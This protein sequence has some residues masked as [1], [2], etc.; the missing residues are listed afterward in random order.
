MTAAGN[1]AMAR[2]ESLASQHE[3][4]MVKFIGRDLRQLL[5]DRLRK[6]G[7]P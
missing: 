4:Q 2:I 5:L 1:E 3:R 7:K 6:F